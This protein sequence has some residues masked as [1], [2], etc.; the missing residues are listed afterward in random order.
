MDYLESLR[1]LKGSA[2]DGI[3]RALYERDGRAFEEIIVR[4]A[5]GGETRDY[6]IAATMLATTL[7][8]VGPTKNNYASARF[9]A[10]DGEE[11]L[12]MFIAACERFGL[13]E[14]GYMPMLLHAQYAKKGGALNSWDKSVDR[15]LEKIARDDFERAAIL[16][17]KY[18]RKFGKYSVLIKVDRP[19][20]V[21]RLIGMALYGKNINKAAVRDVLMDYAE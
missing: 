18:D 2:L 6:E 1:G 13:D 14:N 5:C 7:V 12:N 20:S 10:T 17:D 19:R 11:Y 9:G 3:A 8:S 4:L 21:D 16:V 15:Y